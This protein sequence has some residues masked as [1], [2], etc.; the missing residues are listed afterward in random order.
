MKLMTP[1][2]VTATFIGIYAFI[3]LR[4]K[5]AGRQQSA[6]H[7]KAIAN[8]FINAYF[9]F[10]S[11]FHAFL[12]K[13]TL[14]IFRC[15]TMEDGKA[16]LDVE[17]SIECYTEEWYKQLPLAFLAFLVYGARLAAGCLLLSCVLVVLRLSLRPLLVLT[18]SSQPSASRRSSTSC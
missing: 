12:C 14:E 3:V 2:L 11:L 6:R 17:P 13:N 5:M 10:L 7:G 18:P 9:M 1:F 8:A 15:R 16:Y 4:N